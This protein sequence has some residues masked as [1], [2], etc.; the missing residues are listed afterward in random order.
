MTPRV[1]TILRLVRR[2]LVRS[3]R[4]LPDNLVIATAQG[5]IANHLSDWSRARELWSVVRL[6]APGFARAYAGEIAALAALGRHRELRSLITES[7]ERFPHDCNIR[8]LAEEHSDKL[9][10]YEFQSLGQNCEFGLVQRFFG[11]DPISL[12]RWADLAPRALIEMLDNECFGIGQEEQTTMVVDNGEYCLYDQRY[13]L[14][15]HTFVSSTQDYQKTFKDSCERLAYLGRQLIEDLRDGGIFIYS[16]A[17]PIKESLVIDLHRAIHR[18]G[19][20]SLLYVTVENEHHRCGHLELLEP[21]LAIGYIDKL[22]PDALD[23]GNHT[24]WNPSVAAWKL[25][26]KRAYAAFRS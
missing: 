26:C 12:L 18:L 7:V 22:G 17:D 21:G 4:F 20:S 6:K 15:A 3:E 1:T 16:S 13:G 25:L 11:A 24:P 10:M 19:P 8:D 5:L 2:F 14:A 9:L 23:I